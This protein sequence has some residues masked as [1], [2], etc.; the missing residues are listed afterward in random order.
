[1]RVAL[2][3]APRQLVTQLLA[4][5]LVL[6]V[7]GAVRRPA[8]AAAA[9][10]AD[11]AASRRSTSRASRS[12][13]RLRA[14][15]ASASSSPCHHALLRR[16]CR[17]WCSL[18]GPSPPTSRRGERGS[19]SGARR[20]YS[21][22]V[23]G[24]VALACALL[25]SSALLVR[26]VGRMMET[27]DRRRGRR[28]GHH[29]RCSCSGQCLS[30]RGRSVASTHARP[31]SSTS[32]S[33]PASSSPG[34]TNFLPLEVGWRKPFGIEGE[35]PP[36]RPEDAP[37]AQFHSVSD[38]YFEALGAPAG[39][40]TRVHRLRRGRVGAGGH[41]QRD[42]RPALP[43]RPPAGRAGPGQRR[44]GHRPAR[45]AT[46]SRSRARRTVRTRYEVIGVVKDVRNVPLGQAVEP[47]IY[48]STRQFP[49]RKQFLVVRATDPG[50]AASGDPRGAR[51]RGAPT[52]R[53]ARSRP[54]ASA[55]RRAPPRRGCS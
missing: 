50:V 43:R 8:A 47:A 6:S 42:V 35:P 3:A 13:R 29:V 12:G 51:G 26:T 18:R 40:G 22:L 1:M 20:I 17:R 10:A 37:Q 14:P 16:W 44:H 33:S 23:A 54:G 21:V 19:S 15:S 49:F 41:R 52:C 11:R 25:V 31:S 28:G 45:R 48:F 38:G 53:W 46:W 30:G 7:A 5:S 9:A 2:G 36:A 24:E 55:S 4:E 27:P 39:R 32:A 34:S